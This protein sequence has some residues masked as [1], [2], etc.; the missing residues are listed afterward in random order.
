M[1][2]ATPG[3]GR[4]PIATFKPTV[5]L[6][7]DDHTHPGNRLAV[8]GYGRVPMARSATPVPVARSA[9]PAGGTVR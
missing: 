7:G 1:K 6:I 2:L 5:D 8:N 9:T 3:Y 4:V